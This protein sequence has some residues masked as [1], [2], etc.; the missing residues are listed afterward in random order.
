VGKLVLVASYPKSGNTWVRAFLT[1]IWNGGAV[2]INH[3]R[4]ES[5][6]SRRFL[7]PMLGVSSTHFAPHELA[8]I[9]PALYG[10][11][12]RRGSAD[13]RQFLKIHDAWL[14]P[15]AG[16]DLPVRHEDIDRILYIVRDPRDVAISLARHLGTT[17]DE[18]INIMADTVFWLSSYPHRA[19]QHVQQFL[20][21]WSAHVESWLAPGPIPFLYVRYEDLVAAPLAKFSEV[22]EFLRI[23]TT[24]ESIELA[25]QATQFQALQ[26]QEQA[27]GFVEKP[28]G[29]HLF[30]H[31]GRPRSWESVLTSTQAAAVE[32]THGAVMGRLDY[33]GYPAQRNMLDQ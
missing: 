11:A 19:G 17:I 6:S 30:F 26:K 32:A 14:A 22:I 23:K 7:D 33:A 10:L 29:S 12:M 21:S 13:K 16:I 27:Q 1:A 9:R 15:H 3:L 28:T 2:D 4:I 18:S 31:G 8:R 20:S 25:I 24:A 5:A